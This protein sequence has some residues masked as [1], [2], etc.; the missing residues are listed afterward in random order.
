MKQLAVFCA[1]RFDPQK[2]YLKYF[3]QL[4]TEMI[5]LKCDLVY[6][7][8][9]VGYMR[10]LAEIIAQS[11]SKLIGVMP[12]FLVDKELVFEDCD[13][14]IYTEDMPSRITK[15]MN[16]SDGLIAMPGGVGTYEEVLDMIS[17]SQVGLHQKPIAIFNADGFYDGLQLQLNRGVE[18]GLVSFSIW[19]NVQFFSDVREMLA[20]LM[21]YQAIEY[22]DIIDEQ[23]QPTALVHPRGVPLGPNQ[24]HKVV[25]MAVINQHQQILIQKRAAHVAHPNLWDITAGGS[26]LAGETS[27]NGARREF[28][29]ELGIEVDVTGNQLI[30]SFKYGSLWVDFYVIKAN[31]NVADLDFSISHEVVDAK[32]V[33]LSEMKAMMDEKIFKHGF[34]QQK[35]VELLD[36]VIS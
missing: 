24:Y 30:E 27:L 33:S 32:Y 25:M 11:D 13:E 1:S 2:R 26:V 16:L 4:A 3:K 23:G 14:F 29:E 15:I 17:W 10:Y 19:T 22:W 34:V 35:I 5:E 36:E 31:I 28:V 7:G 18:D 20:W 12:H 9:N 6:G 8:A 21:N